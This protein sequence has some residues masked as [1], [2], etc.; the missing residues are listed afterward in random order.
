MDN[1][2]NIALRNDL[3]TIVETFIS[4]VNSQPYSI[5]TITFN[6]LHLSLVVCGLL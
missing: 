5:F 3:T 1:F 2:V 4:S 6:M